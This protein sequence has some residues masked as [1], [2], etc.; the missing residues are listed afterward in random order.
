MFLLLH[1]FAEEAVK[2]FP[3]SDDETVYV[4]GDGSEKGKQGKKNPLARKGRKSKSKPWFFGIRF[5]VLAVCWDVFRIPVDF[6]IILPRDHPDYKNEN[7]L[8]REMV[9]KFR[10][11]EWAK[12]VIVMGDAAY[13]SKDNMKAV[14][15]RD[16]AD[17]KR[18]WFF[19]FAIARTWKQQNGKSIKNLARHIAHKF[20]RRTWIPPLCKGQRRKVFW[21]YGKV[22][23]LRHLG[24]VTVVL[25]KKG[26]NSSPEKTKIIVTNLPNATA[27]QAISIYRRRW[28]VEIIFKELKSGLGLGEHQVTKKEDRTE[29]S[30]GV[31]IIAYLFLLRACRKEIRQGESWSIFRLQN[32]FRLKVITNHIRH[33][34][35]LEIK[36]LEKAS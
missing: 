35:K 25:S 13:G 27:R 1:W 32:S 18:R 4:I 5:I 21:V 36:K 33:S 10:P 8:F 24:E 30:L 11:P 34:T 26:P 6:R 15:K 20:F 9:E 16:R 7:R 22:I 2:S 23:C 12:V 29:K 14:V 31:A 3:P 17:R 28:A 19:V